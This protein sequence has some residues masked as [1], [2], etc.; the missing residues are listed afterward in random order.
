MSSFTCS[1]HA[2]VAAHVSPGTRTVVFV[3]AYV[4]SP[5]PN[6]KYMNSVAAPRLVAMIS[7]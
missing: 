2:R 5:E 4:V 7:A 6:P 3:M 1:M